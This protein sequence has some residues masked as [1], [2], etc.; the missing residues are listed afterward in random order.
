MY[1]MTLYVKVPAGFGHLCA[2][3]F[4][5]MYVHN[6]LT[7]VLERLNQQTLSMY[8]VNKAVSVLRVYV[9]FQHVE[10]QNADFSRHIVECQIVE[11]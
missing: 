8:K 1:L 4:L 11:M 5:N 9:E 3:K 7:R 2:Q 10:R 6:C